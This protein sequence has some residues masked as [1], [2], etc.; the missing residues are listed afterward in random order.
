MKRQIGILVHAMTDRLF[1]GTEAIISAGLVCCPI[2]GLI[3]SR[4]R[5][6]AALPPQLGVQWVAHE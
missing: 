4:D 2:P 3:R 6:A 5:G 1:E